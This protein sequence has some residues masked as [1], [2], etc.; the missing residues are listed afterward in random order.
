MIFSKV[1]YLPDITIPNI[2]KVTPPK[3]I[4][5]GMAKICMAW[6]MPMY[7]TGAPTAWPH[8]NLSQLA[9]TTLGSMLMREI[10][11]ST[12]RSSRTNE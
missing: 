1:Q 8:R 6:V 4:H 10:T 7:T 11:S 2:S 9:D 3:V 12:A 5:S